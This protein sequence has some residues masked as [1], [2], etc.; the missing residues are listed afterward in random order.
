MPTG[1]DCLA[2][3]LAA[4][5]QE[6]PFTVAA[7]EPALAAVRGGPAPGL[8]RLA[9]A[10]AL[11]F[12]AGARHDRRALA[13]YLLARRR[14]ERLFA[15]AAETLATAPK[16]TML[17]LPGAP[18]HF[19]VPPLTTPGELAHWLGVPL[20]QLWA[21]TRCWRPDP[22]RRDDRLQPWH[23]RWRP[24]RRGPPRL[25]EVPKAK[26]KA[27]QRRILEGLLASIPPHEAAHGFVRGRSV[28]SFVAPHEGQP[29]VLRLDVQ[30]F[31]AS[32]GAV[33]VRRVFTSVGYPPTVAALLAALCTTRTPKT[34]TAPLQAHG[35]PGA[36]LAERLHAR[37]LPQGAPTSPA[38]ANLVAFGLDARL[39]GLARR[40]GAVYTRY[41]DD[42][43]F[44]GGADFAR[45]SARC[46][47]YVAAV[48]LQEG[49]TAAHHKTRRLRQGTAQHVGGLV[50]NVHAAVPRPERE[51]LEAMLVNCV[52]RGPSTQNHDQHPDF[53]AHL[54]GRIAHVEHAHAPHA[55]RLHALFSQIDWRR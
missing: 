53:Q 37:H 19:R 10:L 13:D 15:D 22:E 4:V 14:F 52:R 44:S 40:F 27:A 32:I 41:A 38:L 28:R 17:P 42:L 3:S 23:R 34:V 5:L 47:T 35:R 26:L 45:A 1:L 46:A 30:D 33:R 49:F 12:P 11:R 51:R 31:F 20:D 6:R 16:P 9:T 50:L 48:L 8:R 55:R 25:L 54:R 43:V 39:H 2:R 7:I 24:R 36:V 21:W 29:C 18:Q